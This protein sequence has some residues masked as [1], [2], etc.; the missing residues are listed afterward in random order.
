M[1]SFD[2]AAFRDF[3]RAA[4]GR[5]A[6]SY[7]DL[8]SAVTG[9]AVAPLLD[10]VKV[11]AR[12]RLLD[13]ASGPG[14]LAAEAAQR[15]ANVTGV[16]LAPE[17]V[18]L[19]SRLYPHVTFR[20]AQA[21][22]LP[23]ADRSFDAVT[24]AFGAGHF[25]EP[26]RVVA[27]FARVLAPG[28]ITALAWWAGFDRNRINGVFHETI[29]KLGITAAGAVPAGPPVDRFSDRERFAGLLRGAGL[30]GV[31]VN[32]VAFDHALRDADA[33]WAMAMGSFA[34][35]SAVIGAQSEAVQR[36][37]KVAVAQAAARYKTTD[38]LA[39][40]VAFLIASGVRA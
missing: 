23:F 4:H 27:E 17:M 24:C 9:R 13:V 14:H 18:A 12:T 3:E 25:P 36:E 26:E 15:G 2:A 31:Q 29:L 21:E 28:G 40:P 5:K 11:R 39:I 16:D 20:E 30:S 38:G 8:F 32:E 22:R 33:L 35:A 19:A 6:S 7:H 10:A 1:T 34:R 37:I